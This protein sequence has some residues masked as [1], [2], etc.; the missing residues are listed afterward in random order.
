MFRVYFILFLLA[1]VLGDFYLQTGKMAEK[2]TKSVKWVFI[3]SL[4]YLGVMLLTGLTMMSWQMALGATVAAV[5][6]CI[7][8][9]IKFIYVSRKS[10]KR[11]LTQ[12]I[13]RNVFFIDQLIHCIILFGIAYWLVSN[14]VL[15]QP[16]DVIA[17]FFNILGI[18]VEQVLNWLFALLLIHKPANIAI[19][20]LLMLYKP[21]NAEEDKK[22]DKSAG[23]FIGTVERIIMLI[24]L[25]IA[26]YSAIGLV[27][28]AKSIARYDRISK[29]KDFAE[30]YLLGTLISTV[31]VIVV[32]FLL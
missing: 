19:S 25:S 24:F 11:K 22:N 20:K 3:H 5:L 9:I 31:I 13:D 1:H 14:N 8:D 10:K 16:A 17:N 15:L 4:C 32:S 7:I 28:T 18:P 2:K 6:H 26:Q 21:V 12:I 30:Y 23:R 29:E 27:L